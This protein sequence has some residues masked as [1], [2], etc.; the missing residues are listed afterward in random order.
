[1]TIFKRMAF[2]FMMIA[3]PIVAVSDLAR[4]QQAGSYVTPFPAKGTYRIYVF[5]DSLGDGIGAALSNAF[6]R[7]ADV[8]VI[9]KSKAG[10]GFVRNDIYD[11]NNTATQ[12]AKREN[13]DI[14]IAM[15]GINDRQSMR[16]KKRRFQLNSREWLR[17]YT[18]RVDRFI[19]T[20]KQKNI[21]LYW[22]GLPIMKSSKANSAMQ[23][24][25]QIVREKA[26][27]N[28]VKYI[29]TWN[30]FTDQDGGYSASGPDLGGR[31][32]RLRLNDGVHFTVGGYQKLAHY[33]EREIRRDI[34]V[35]KAERSIP[36]A[37]G[38]EEQR[39]IAARKRIQKPVAR[40]V[41]PVKSD[42]NQTARPANP[43]D[44]RKKVRASAKKYAADHSKITLNNPLAGDEEGKKVIKILRPA[45]PPAVI[46]HILRRVSS[47]KASNV[48]ETVNGPMDG[49]LIATSSITPVSRQLG[50]AQKRNV[51]I[52]Q[53]PY[54][55]VLIKGA[56]LPPKPGRADDFMW[57]Q[58]EDKPAG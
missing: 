21:A 50:S 28:G 12:L 32:K 44:F 46:N 24:I 39:R 31:V 22:V 9:M 26:Y 13:F 8:Q 18:D 48:G 56:I 35:A 33:V 25:N 3:A 20:L 41:N 19:K 29:D 37:G 7:E 49:G 6:Q 1:M 10:T 11:W 43:N 36:L 42:A 47:L 17:E 27:L 53:S 52:T 54:Y 55:R 4:A 58:A 40:K 34:S 51:P 57:R 5:G 30:G 45:I 38:A 2:L 23:I 16:L 15:F 14:A